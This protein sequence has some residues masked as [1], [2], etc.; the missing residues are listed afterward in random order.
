MVTCITP[1]T[2]STYVF[3]SLLLERSFF[4]LTYFITA[5]INILQITITH[6][7]LVH[8]AAVAIAPGRDTKHR[9]TIAPV[10]RNKYGRLVR[11][12]RLDII[13]VAKGN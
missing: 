8:T 5:A 7:Y 4:F 3:S 12:Y 10:N 1:D 13:R 2:N 11:P 9:I 6:I